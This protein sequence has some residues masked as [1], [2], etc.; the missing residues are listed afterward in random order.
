MPGW[1]DSAAPASSP[2]PVTTLIA[3][4]GKPASLGDAGEGERGEAGFLRRFQH[5]GVARGQ[6]GADAAAD[7]LHRIVPGNDMAG[8]AMRLAQGAAPYS[9]CR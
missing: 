1:A 9:R 5:R 6:R 3:P 8:D 4:A 2:R 7:D